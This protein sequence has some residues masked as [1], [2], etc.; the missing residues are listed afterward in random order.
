MT[1][2][3]ENIQTNSV[4]FVS[5]KLN[6]QAGIS[7]FGTLLHLARL[8]Y[9]H[10][11]DFCAAFGLRFTKWDDISKLLT[12]SPKR[13]KCLAEA[14]NLPK[15][16]V[17]L[18]TVD[19]WQPFTAKGIW[20]NVPWTLRACASCARFGYH[21]TLFQM[22]WVDQCPWHRERLI[23]QCRR[24]D[25]PL[26]TG[27]IEGNDLLK[28]VCGVDYVN[29]NA[30]LKTDVRVES[31]RIAFINDYRSWSDK[32]KKDSL[33]IYPEEHD[34]H[35]LKTLASLIQLPK[36][37]HIRANASKPIEV[38]STHVEKYSRCRLNILSKSDYQNY[39]RLAHSVW[40]KDTGIANLPNESIMSI[41]KISH[42]LTNRLPIDALTAQER[43]A[44]LLEDINDKGLPNVSRYYFLLAPLK[45]GIQGNYLDLHILHKTASRVIA[46]LGWQFLNNDP[47]RQFSESGSHYLLIKTLYRTLYRSYADGLAHLFWR[48]FPEIFNSHRVK[49]GPRI[50]WVHVRSDS[51]GAMETIIA[52][53][54]RRNSDAI[55]P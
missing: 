5:A 17:E 9:F 34:S 26:L 44:F 19:S 13:M 12:F 10:R 46:N 45:T 16:I 14:A 20:E 49:S 24:C 3:N 53:S 36:S 4:G 51:A 22:P 37:L 32:C 39:V 40:T 43:R 6:Q 55:T 54:P 2:M 33:I 48:E 21:S 8:N 31:K 25:R 1:D 23:T 30:I 42:E 29:D 15:K 28:C 38:N 35:G 7:G 47:A 11:S 50:P 41:Q 52:W 27:F 18:W